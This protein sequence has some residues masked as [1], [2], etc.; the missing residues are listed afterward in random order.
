LLLVTLA[1]CAE[2]RIREDAQAEMANGRYDSAI[3]VLQ[4]GV[5]K[6]PDSVSLRSGL[7]QARDEA[8][9]HAVAQ[10]N[11]L[12]AS[13]K[14]DEAEAELQHVA[15]LDPGN[16]RI[17]ALIGELKIQRAQHAAWLDAR[18][19]Q[20]GGSADAAL[21][22]VDQSLKDNPRNSELLGLQR[23]LQLA[24]HQ[25]LLHAG[26]GA[27]AETRPISLDFR[28]ADLRSVLDTVSRS[29]GIDF[30]LDKDVRADSRVTVY[31]RQAKVQDALDFIT[32][33][34][35]LAMK[36]IDPKTV[37]IYPNTAEKQRDYQDQVLRVFY[38]ANA[39]AKNAASYLK[40]MLHIKDPFVDDRTNMLTVRE[41]PE[42]M[43]LVERLV[44]L[45]DS[46]EPE[47]LLEVEVLEVSSTRLTE[48][49]IQFPSSVT[50]TPVGPGFNGQLTLGNVGSLSKDN[51]V[52]GVGP[53]TINLRRE[54]G[55]FSTLA[56]PKI[57]VKNKEKAKV[58]VGDK[59][60]VITTTTGIAGFVSDNVTYL[61]VGIKLDVQPT[62]YADD[63]VAMVVG[64][65]VS[66]LGDAIKTTSGTLAYQI[67]TR[68]ASTT[69]RLHD[70]ET[71]LLAGLI[72]HDDRMN[73]SRLPG[74]GDLPVLGRLF[75]SQLDNGQRTEIVLAITPRVL[76]NLHQPSA[77]ES[78]LWVGTDSAPRLRE[79]G[80]RLASADG[81]GS[82]PRADA[83]AA[84]GATLGS[85]PSPTNVSDDLG[86]LTNDASATPGAAPPLQL[87]WRGPTHAHVGD[88]VELELAAHSGSPIRGLSA[89]VSFTSATGT[90]V[91][92]SEGTFLKQAGGE[93]RFSKSA[94]G[95]DTVSVGSVRQS[96][97][98][99]G[100][101][102]VYRLAFKPTTAGELVVRVK[103]AKA[104]VETGATPKVMLPPAVRLQVK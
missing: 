57:R 40:Q 31:L 24:R 80:G 43:E 21:A 98:A 54:V 14:F 62:V 51:I 84:T 96:G 8:L 87:T 55:D 23:D 71:Q 44:A 4:D 16:E 47:V 77:N 101:G 89:D 36:I 13:G 11:T 60:P 48:L 18:Q 12:R 53:A 103:D 81:V 42:N 33:A 22:L 94:A 49:G 45:Y 91:D 1:G 41:S 38:L 17:Q 61:D 52:L 32:G 3:A 59:V 75:S 67:G 69:L 68:N 26:R 30:I 83:V 9:T 73:A 2:Q 65:E 34:N 72:S 97:G 35:Q 63:D 90:F 78:E 37:M 56:N 39:D 95:A 104:T 27:L 20:A 92:A 58:M 10:A 64:L 85:A 66:T 93:T 25:A 88:T 70:G 86:A 7:V 6:Y 46:A 19:L 76:R 29:S 82:A 100:D 79:P 5:S 102:I 50:L 15:A 99:S 74:I 28:S